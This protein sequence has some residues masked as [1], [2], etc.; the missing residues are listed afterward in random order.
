MS[1]PFTL[2]VNGITFHLNGKSMR[3]VVADAAV[4]TM[5]RTE[6]LV[7]VAAFAEV[8]RPEILGEASK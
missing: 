6:W 2:T 7:V 1:E 8:Y 4:V 5:S 3:I